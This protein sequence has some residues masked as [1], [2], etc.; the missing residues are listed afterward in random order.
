MVYYNLS[1]I[2]VILAIISISYDNF[3][4]FILAVSTL[5][6]KGSPSPYFAQINILKITQCSQWGTASP[7]IESL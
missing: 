6:L 1:L 7:V 4:F 5:C 2:F 3:V